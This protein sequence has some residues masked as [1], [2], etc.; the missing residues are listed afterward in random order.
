MLTNL[1]CQYLFPFFLLHPRQEC[2]GGQSHRFPQPQ[3]KYA[4]SAGTVAN[5][6]GV[7]RGTFIR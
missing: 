4:V 7:Q 2:P 3:Q 1:L 6:A 5:V